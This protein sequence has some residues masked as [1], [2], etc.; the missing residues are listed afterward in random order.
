LAL[1]K[2]PLGSVET[3]TLKISMDVLRAE[4]ESMGKAHQTTADQM[5][6][7][8]EQPL[9]DYSGAWRER[10]RIVQG[11][12]EKILQS[13]MKQTNQVNKVFPP[14]GHE[15]RKERRK[16]RSMALMKLGAH[17]RLGIVM[18]RIA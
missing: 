18:N 7:E 11:T 15:G 17:I 4:V 8:L 1:S 2:K 9:T 14:Y 10:R 16:E 3:G 6:T 12:C 5:K 13:K